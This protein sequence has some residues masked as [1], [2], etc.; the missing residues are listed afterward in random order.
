VISQELTALPIAVSIAWVPA[1]VK[2]A[3]VVAVETSEALVVYGG[4]GPPIPCPAVGIVHV[5]R[6]VRVVQE[7]GPAGWELTISVSAA[8]LS[9]SVVPINK[10]LVVLL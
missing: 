9:V 6:V 2:N 5:A 7:D 8:E 10:L 4:G 3:L 1:P